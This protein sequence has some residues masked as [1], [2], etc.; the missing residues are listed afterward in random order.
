MLLS[1]IDGQEG[2]QDTVGDG[3]GKST[4]VGAGAK[5]GAGRQHVKELTDQTEVLQF[6]PHISEEFP[7]QGVLQ[8]ELLGDG[9]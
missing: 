5:I 2:E 9:P 1:K 3:A 8:L 7:V 4:S 6:P